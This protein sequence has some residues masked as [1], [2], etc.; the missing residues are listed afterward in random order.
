MVRALGRCG[1]R[2]SRDGGGGEKRM[3]S[4][5]YTSIFIA[6]PCTRTRIYTSM[7]SSFRRLLSSVCVQ[8]IKNRRIVGYCLPHGPSSGFVFRADKG[9]DFA[10]RAE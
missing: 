2:R 6:V 5:S 9:F 10:K 8:G 1:P 4:T 7:I 3:G